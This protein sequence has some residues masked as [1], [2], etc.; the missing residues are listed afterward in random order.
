MGK[1]GV[2]KNMK[3]KKNKKVKKYMKQRKPNMKKIEDEAVSKFLA[4]ET[5]KLPKEKYF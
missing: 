1:I 3:C 5:V 4:G 2:L